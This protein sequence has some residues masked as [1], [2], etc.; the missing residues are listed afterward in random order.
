LTLKTVPA[1]AAAPKA[2]TESS[3]LGF[4][5]ALEEV[6]VYGYVTPLK[7]KIVVAL[8]LTDAVVRD[9]DIISVHLFLLPPFPPPPLYDSDPE[10]TRCSKRC[11]GRIT[12]QRPTRSSNFTHRSMPLRTSTFYK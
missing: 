9:V 5:Y 11:T 1:V 8:A 6:A 3:Y 10:T 4:L 7:L 2:P 12:A